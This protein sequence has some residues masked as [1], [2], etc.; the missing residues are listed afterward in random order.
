M[1]IQLSF[2]SANSTGHSRH[3]ITGFELLKIL[4]NGSIHF[5]QC[6]CILYNSQIGGKSCFSFE[7]RKL[8]PRDMCGYMG[9][10]QSRELGFQ[11]VPPSYQ[12]M[13]FSFCKHLI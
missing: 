11:S 9:K 12:S 7:S 1:C 13:V 10:E 5:F 6:Y 3:H 2:V 4:C 8:G